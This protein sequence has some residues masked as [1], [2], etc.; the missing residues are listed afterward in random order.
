MIYQKILLSDHSMVGDPGALPNNI[1]KMSDGSLA[2]LSAALSPCPQPL[3]GFGWWPVVDV[4]EALGDNQKHDTPELTVDV[5]NLRVL[6]TTPAVDKTTGELSAELV[7]YKLAAQDELSTYIADAEFQITGAISPG[8]LVSFPAK[9]IAARAFQAQPPAAEA[10][11]IASLQA[12]ADVTGETLAE[13]S[14]HI[15]TKANAYTTAEATL[16]GIRRKWGNGL[17]DGMDDATNK[18]GVDTALAGGKGAV[19]SFLSSL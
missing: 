3:I 9:E 19:D 11:Y 13:L 1:R 5:G 17:G 18:A 2:D 16:T 4:V 15:V 14:T 10:H 6:N 12:E 8:E 7:E